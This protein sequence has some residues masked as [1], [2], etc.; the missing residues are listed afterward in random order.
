MKYF[1][2]LGTDNIT[3]NIVTVSDQDAPT[4]AA[5]QNFLSKT[6]QWPAE[7]WIEYSKDASF[8]AN[9]AQ[10]GSTWDPANN[11]FIDVKPYDS[12]TLNTSTW[13]WEAPV[14]IPNQQPQEIDGMVPP[15]WWNESTL[16]W[17]SPDSV[18]NPNTLSWDAN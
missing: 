10:I 14:A 1:A 5:G 2:K 9:A 4:E 12:W 8:K 16:A 15:Y 11:V 13:Q 17:D 7:L 6:Q 18:W 3:I